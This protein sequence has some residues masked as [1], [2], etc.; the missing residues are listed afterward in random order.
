M[1]PHPLA[2]VPCRPPAQLHPESLWLKS[3]YQTLRRLPTTNY[4]LFTVRT[5][6]EPLSF[7]KQAAEVSE[8]PDGGETAVLPAAGGLGDPAST[9]NAGHGSSGRPAEAREGSAAATLARSLRGMTPAM[10]A[11]KGLGAP[12]AVEAVLA[13]LEAEAV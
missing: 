10:Q 2:P 11:Y 1:R 13:Y 5:F 3:E 4:I 9:L 12:G 8:G 6:T 7:L